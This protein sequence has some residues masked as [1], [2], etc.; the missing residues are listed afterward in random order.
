MPVLGHHT[1]EN[2]TLAEKLRTTIEVYRFFN[3]ICITAGF[4]VVQ[5]EQGEGVDTVLIGV[6][7]NLYQRKRADRNITVAVGGSKTRKE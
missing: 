5:Y 4:G 2:R 3:T 6:D 7:N 1:A